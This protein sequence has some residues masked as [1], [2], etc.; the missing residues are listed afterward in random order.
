MK[1]KCFETIA[2][3]RSQDI[4]TYSTV[5]FQ[6]IILRKA[7]NDAKKNEQGKKLLSLNKKIRTAIINT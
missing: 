5:K 6:N 4:P 7:L 1:G 2:R 3:Q